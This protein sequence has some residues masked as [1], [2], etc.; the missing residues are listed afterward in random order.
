MSGGDAFVLCILVIE[1]AILLPLLTWAAYRFW[2][3]RS[4]R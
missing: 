2:R 1:A 3:D 4:A